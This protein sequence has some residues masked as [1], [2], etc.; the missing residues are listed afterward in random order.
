MFWF[1]ILFDF[2][3]FGIVKNVFILLFITFYICNDRFIFIFHGFLYEFIIT[4]FNL[5]FL[6]FITLQIYYYYSINH[7]HNH[8]HYYHWHFHYFMML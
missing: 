4:I 1:D 2:I 5:N 6:T 7:K 8:S 3:V